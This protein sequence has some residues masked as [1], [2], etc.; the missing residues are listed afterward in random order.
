MPFNNF[1]YSYIDVAVDQYKYCTL[2]IDRLGVGN[3][4]IADPLNVIQAP[5]ELSA[6][7]ELTKMLRMGTLPNVPRAFEKIVHVGHSFGASLSYTLAAM[8]PT[9]S[10]GLILTGYSANGSFLP[11]TIASW[12]SKLARL[13][14][15]LRF[16]NVSYAAVQ[17]AVSM[18]GNVNTTAI[19]QYL[20]KFNINLAEVQQVV[21]TTDLADF[22]AGLD[23]SSLPKMADL[24]SGYLTWTD[25]GSNQVS[26]PCYKERGGKVTNN[27]PVRIPVPGALRSRDPLLCRI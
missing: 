21:Q 17:E 3:S 6:L 24:P 25:A 20:A 13:N 22:I 23:P 14:Q 15:P 9:M 2:S 11:S 5:A 16:G 18:V 7:Y 26:N 27:H 10:D 12:N 8:Y 19:D 4:S 1:N